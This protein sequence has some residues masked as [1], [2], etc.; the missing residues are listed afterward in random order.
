MQKKEIEAAGGILSVTSDINS[1]TTV[2]FEIPYFHSGA[3]FLKDDSLGSYFKDTFSEYRIQMLPV[4]GA[5]R[6]SDLQKTDV[7]SNK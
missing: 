1:G 6:L 5:P 4:I 2:S 7:M 3:S